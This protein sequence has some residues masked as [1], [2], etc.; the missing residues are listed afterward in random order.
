MYYFQ[1]AISRSSTPSSSTTYIA[2]WPLILY[3]SGCRVGLTTTSS[4]S[5]CTFW[6]CFRCRSPLL[7]VKSTVAVCANSWLTGA[8]V[9]AAGGSAAISVLAG[10][11]ENRIVVEGVLL[12]TAR[13]F[14]SVGG[15][16]DPVGSDSGTFRN[17]DR[18]GVLLLRPHGSG[19]GRERCL[20]FCWKENKSQKMSSL[21]G[22]L[23]IL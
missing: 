9:L 22:T 8:G 1:T 19:G 11:S 7:A 6:T 2:I 21:H 23:T 15:G 20:L 17:G 10:G 14:W 3:S 5:C 4:D 18:G 12:G 13:L 16:T